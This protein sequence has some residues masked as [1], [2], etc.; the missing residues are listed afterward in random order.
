[1]SIFF[2][3]FYFCFALGKKVIEPGFTLVSGG[4]DFSVIPDFK[5]GDK[6]IPSK[7]QLTEGKTSPPD[8]LTESD[9]LGLMEKHGIGTDASMATHIKNI[10]ERNYVELV[11]LKLFNNKKLK[12]KRL[13]KVESEIKF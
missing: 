11:K 10:C 5:I 13:R 12:T 2:L 3:S 1:M 9:L 6:F 7:I 8:F 4:A